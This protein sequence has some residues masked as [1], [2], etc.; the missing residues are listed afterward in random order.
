MFYKPYHSNN[1]YLCQYLINKN[2]NDS[3]GDETKL[4]LIVLHIHRTK[5]VSH[6]NIAGTRIPVS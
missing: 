4:K 6:A 2:T 3:L 5:P 1:V